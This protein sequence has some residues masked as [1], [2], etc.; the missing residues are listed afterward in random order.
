MQIY[1]KGLLLVMYNQA[2]ATPSNPCLLTVKVIDISY[3]MWNKFGTSML[4]VFS[5]L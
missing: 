4:A 5:V 1:L 3:G 2:T